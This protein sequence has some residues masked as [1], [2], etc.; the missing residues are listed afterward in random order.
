MRRPASEQEAEELA[1]DA[2]RHRGFVHLEPAVDRGD[3]EVERVEHVGRVV[4][5]AVGQDVRLDSLE[6]A[7]RR[8]AILE[9]VDLPVL[10]RANPAEPY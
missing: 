9:R 4:E 2:L 1:E 6:D 10:G 5:R 3:H 8:V 7:D